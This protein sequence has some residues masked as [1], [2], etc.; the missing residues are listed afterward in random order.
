MQMFDINQLLVGVQ[1]ISKILNGFLI[2]VSSYTYFRVIIDSL[3]FGPDFTQSQNHKNEI[4]VNI[5][6]T[7]K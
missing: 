5:K 3:L 2:K 4:A 7:A 1:M 6:L